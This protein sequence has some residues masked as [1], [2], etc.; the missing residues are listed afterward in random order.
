ML[1][2]LPGTW[3]LWRLSR[4]DRAKQLSL[5]VFGLSLTACYAGSFLFHAV[6]RPATAI[7]FYAT[8]DHLGIFLLIAGTSTPV[9]VVVL[10]GA[11]RAGLLGSIWFL[12]V[13][14]SVLR[15]ATELTLPQRTGLYLAMGWL[16]CVTYFE[17]AR[18]L[19]HAKLR[20]VW[21]GGLFYSVGAVL[22]FEH[23]PVLWPGVFE[24]HELFHLFVMAGSLCHYY[25]MLRVVVPYPRVVGPSDLVAS[26][27]D[28]ITYLRPFAADPAPK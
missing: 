15:L 27:A 7:E 22:N 3:T 18:R 17:L 9:G 20:P 2:S 23:W 24:A 6:R 16:G 11:W 14:G 10:R 4:G 19:S 26:P 5:L 28:S 25:F 13:A 21:V 12:A 8:L 1:L